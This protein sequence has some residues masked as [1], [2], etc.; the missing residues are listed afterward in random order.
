MSERL[1]ISTGEQYHDIRFNLMT[2][3]PDR[4]LAITHKLKML[5]TN[6]QIVLDALQ[7]L[8]KIKHSESKSNKEEQEVKKEKVESTP[9]IEIKAEETET[10]ASTTPQIEVK[11]EDNTNKNEGEL[12]EMKEKVMLC[13]LD[14]STPLTIQTSPAPS[15]SS[16]DTSSEIGS[17]FNSPTQA[18]NWAAAQNSPTSKDFKRF[19]VLKVANDEKESAKT[20][21]FLA[22]KPYVPNTKNFLS[23]KRAECQW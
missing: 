15:T 7:Q 16:T 9:S 5:K 14:Y 18:W 21:N 19:V 4:R 2:V 20:G 22:L 8:M 23:F 13:P 17:A 10:N 1:G 6:K 3:V 12:A 11:N